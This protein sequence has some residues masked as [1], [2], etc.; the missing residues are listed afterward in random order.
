ML[1]LK[2][3][4]KQKLLEVRMFDSLGAD[5][6]KTFVDKR[7]ALQANRLRMLGNPRRSSQLVTRLAQSPCQPHPAN[8]N[9]P[10]QRFRGPPKWTMG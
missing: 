9:A 7:L 3:K 1:S 4:K 8:S 2:K 5:E 6:K 10:I